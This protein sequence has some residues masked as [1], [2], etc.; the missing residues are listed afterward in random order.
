MLGWAFW[1]VTE[2]EKDA[3]VFLMHTDAMAPE[4]RKPALALE[5]ERRLAKP[6]QVLEQHL[7]RVA[8][9]HTDVGSGAHY[10]TRAEIPGER[11]FT[12]SIFDSLPGIKN[13]DIKPF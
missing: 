4:R 12:R 10:L 1:A 13:I 5:A 11:K 9:R 3:L 2:C 6:L 8:S 7:E